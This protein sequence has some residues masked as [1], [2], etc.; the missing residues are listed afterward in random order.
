[1]KIPYKKKMEKYVYDN[2]NGYKK[3]EKEKTKR[4]QIF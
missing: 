1:V 2:K 3:N 4:F